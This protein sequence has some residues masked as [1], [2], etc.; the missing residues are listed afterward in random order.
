VAAES[1]FLK[2]IRLG[3]RHDLKKQINRRPRVAHPATQTQS[4]TPARQRQLKFEDF[5]GTSTEDAEHQ[6]RQAIGEG[7]LGIE[8]VRD[9]WE[10]SSTAQG[11]TSDAT[12]REVEKRIPKEAF[13]RQDPK[14]IQ[15]GQS[16]T[17]EVSESEEFEAR[18]AWRRH[19]PRGAQLDN[20]ECVTPPKN[21]MMGIGKKPGTWI[22][23]W[24]APFIAEV[25]YKMP[26]VVSAR[27]FA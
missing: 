7:L 8:I 5:M 22:V 13:D 4:G 18:K 24:S 3:I 25:A 11:R 6:A 10:K 12:L 15:E 17:V 20:L 9:V 23:H 14:I 2:Q 1:P 19:A 26:A 21:G 27:Y 16:G